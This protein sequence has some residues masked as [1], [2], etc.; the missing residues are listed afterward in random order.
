MPNYYD[1]LGIARSADAREIRQAFRKLARQH[2][3]D[4]NPGDK[5]AE[6]TFKL[7]NEAH[8]V[9]S[10]P[11]SR[12]KYDRYGDNW[13]QADQLDQAAAQARR[14]TTEPTPF[15]WSPPSREAPSSPASGGGGNIFEQLFR[16]IGQDIRRPA[17]TEYPV[18]LTLEEAFQGAARVMELTGD[19]RIEVKIPSGVDNASKVHIP[20]AGGKDAGFNLAISVRPHPIFQRKGKDLYR[21]IEVSLEDAILGAEVTVPTLSGRVALT[22]P[23]D[24]QNGQRFRMTRQGMP[25]LN[26]PGVRGDLYTTVKVV[27]PTGLTAEEK[28]FVRRLKESRA[29]RGG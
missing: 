19:R 1:V 26:Q 3:P 2:H 13:G 24:T 11:D 21:E 9:L 15:S 25:G 7:I 14:P 6:E 29:S 23:A 8:S 4:V 5:T 22:I 28:E 17:S 27:L 12:R 16:N 18:V 10:E 20:G